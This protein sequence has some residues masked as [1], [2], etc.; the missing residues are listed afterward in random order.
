MVIYTYTYVLDLGGCLL[1]T[2]AGPKGHKS[3]TGLQPLPQTL[4]F[5]QS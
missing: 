2:S 5:S 3:H 1:L 4:V